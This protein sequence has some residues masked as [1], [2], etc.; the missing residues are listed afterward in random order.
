M[1]EGLPKKWPKWFIDL[2]SHQGLQIALDELARLDDPFIGENIKQEMQGV[3]DGSGVD[4]GLIRRVHFIAELTQGQCSMVGAW[5]NV[6]QN[7]KTL[8]MRSFDW[9]ADCPCR[10]F[11][12]ILV[13]HPSAKGSGQPW[14]N[15]G[16][17]GMLGSFTAMSSVHTAT[18]MIGV[19]FPDSTFGEQK[20]VGI[21][22]IFLMRDI[23]QFDSSYLE[24]I[25]RIQKANRTCDLIVGLGDGNAGLFRGI[26]YSAAVA[27]VF[28]DT[29]MM[30]F[31]DTWHPRM[32]QVLY[33][34]M[35]WLCPTFT[36]VLAA[37]I[38]RHYGSLTPEVTILD[39]SSKVQTGNVHEAV[40]DLTDNLLYVSFEG[41]DNSTVPGLP[42]WAYERQFT[43]L[44]ATS[45]F[46]QALF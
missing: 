24:S 37:A 44:N 43:K 20:F 31:N 28:D 8:M 17:P 38:K 19:E 13:Y 23:A 30:P 25:N 22:F 12:A 29:N 26:E 5:G 27:N 6:T 14:L 33:W 11:P 39:V 2:V 4:L 35:D 15:I 46:L 3:A 18:A 9:N 10:N 7:N 42:P 16:W 41:R 40:F 1:A 34:G 36:S 45:L 32:S 21:P